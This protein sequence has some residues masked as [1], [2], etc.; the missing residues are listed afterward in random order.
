M[1]C[2]SLPTPST[3]PRVTGSGRG[4]RGSHAP[5]P[6][7][8][9]LARSFRPLEST[10]KPP[11]QATASGALTQSATFSHSSQLL[12]LEVSGFGELQAARTAASDATRIH[13]VDFMTILS[14]DSRD[15]VLAD[16]LPRIKGDSLERPR[17]LHPGN[18]R[19]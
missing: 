4:W 3:V 19:R 9:L 8:T 14:V 15:A 18:R 16:V 11:V 6:S 1:P 12:E 10:Q 13:L 5:P 17:V 2:A 7:A